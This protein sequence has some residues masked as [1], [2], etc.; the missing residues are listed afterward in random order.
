MITKQI[1][2][3]AQG[4]IQVSPNR[5]DDFTDISIK[6]LSYMLRENNF[7]LQTYQLAIE[8]H[9]LPTCIEFKVNKFLGS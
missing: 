4:R 9:K 7:Y 3:V 1:S 8:R 5:S 6:L 2:Q